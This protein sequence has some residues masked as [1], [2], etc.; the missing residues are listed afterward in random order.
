MPILQ[1]GRGRG[2]SSTLAGAVGGRLPV[3]AGRLAALVGVRLSKVTPC[4][5]CV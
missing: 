1:G 4:G 5:L 2:Q 3:S